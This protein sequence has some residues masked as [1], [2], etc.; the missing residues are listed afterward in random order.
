MGLGSL[1]N[2]PGA[3]YPERPS[4]ELSYQDELGR[5]SGGNCG[6]GFRPQ[7]TQ[8]IPRNPLNSGDLCQTNAEQ[9]AN[10]SLG[11]SGNL[12]SGEPCRSGYWCPRRG[13]DFLSQAP[14]IACTWH[15]GKSFVPTVYQRQESSSTNKHEQRS[16][17][18]YRSL[19]GRQGHGY[20][21]RSN[22]RTA[23]W[24]PRVSR[25]PSAVARNNQPFACSVLLTF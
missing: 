2:Y 14:E 20:G 13:L 25:S 23:C 9:K 1:P 5:K 19:S 4:A 8:S 15:L 17:M 11:F 7:N 10:L 6:S 3:S 24:P 22:A 12:I 21:D 16:I 18:I